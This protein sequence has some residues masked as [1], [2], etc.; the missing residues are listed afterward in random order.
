M[1]PPTT[2]SV[3][4]IRHLHSAILAL[5]L[6][7]PE[8]TSGEDPQPYRIHSVRLEGN[9]KTRDDILLRESLLVPGDV[10]QQS[11]AQKTRVRLLSLGIFQAVTIKPDTPAIDRPGF[12]DLVVEV[13]ELRR[14]AL[15]GGGSFSGSEGPMGTLDA[16]IFNLRGRAHHVSTSVD[17]GTRRRRVSLGFRAPW[18]FG[19]RMPI[20]LHATVLSQDYVDLYHR[21]ADEIGVRL[22]RRRRGLS[23]WIGLLFQRDHYSDIPVQG[24]PDAFSSGTVSALQLGAS[25]GDESS[26]GGAANYLLELAL[27]GPLSDL[28]FHRHELNISW[29]RPVGPRYGLALSTLTALIDGITSDDNSR[30]GP[31]RR[32][33]P[34]G[35]DWFDGQVRGYPDHSLGPRVGGLPVGGRVMAVANLELRRQL[36]EEIYGFIFADI[37]NAWESASTVDVTELKRSSGIGVLLDLSSA[38]STAGFSLG[39]GFDRRSVDGRPGSWRFHFQITPRTY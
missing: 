38:R 39:Y 4:A 25:V 22:D 28:A 26:A 18:V 11:L 36:R 32:Y 2:V 24:N 10:Y 19:Q 1:C 29:H 20:S 34:G 12:V 37:G 5:A 3:M 21:R 7:D 17:L 31:W 14:G 15:F 35:I 9:E 8:M 30:L 16:E 23:Q 13:V 27:P 33:T 6:F